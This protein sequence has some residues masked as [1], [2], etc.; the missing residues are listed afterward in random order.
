[1]AAQL[2]SAGKQTASRLGALAL[3]VRQRRVIH[4]TMPPARG[5]FAAPTLVRTNACRALFQV[6]KAPMCPSRRA[7]Q[8]NQ[9]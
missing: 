9:S 1:M 6:R 8:P 3:K 5:P 4:D 7:L 2:A